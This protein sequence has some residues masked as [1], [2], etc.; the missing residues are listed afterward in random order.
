MQKKCVFCGFQD[1]EMIVYEDEQ[2]FAVISKEPI[3]PYHMMVFPQSHY[4]SFID[5]PDDLAAHLFVIAKRL[6]ATLRE[7]CHPDA[8]THISDDDI[9]HSGFNLV[10]HYKLHLIPRYKGDKV[11]INWH[12]DDDPGDEVRAAYARA[13]REKLQNGMKP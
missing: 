3:N 7:V 12:R 13:V 5:L 11:E 9:T 10:A 6:S 4:E 2:V 1:R 8:I